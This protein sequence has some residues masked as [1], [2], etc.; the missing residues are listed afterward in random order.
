[1]S[2]WNK[3]SDLDKRGIESLYIDSEGTKE[4]RQEIIA[5]KYG[6]T[7]R[8][9]RNW[10]SNLGITSGV[11]NKAFSTHPQYLKALERRLPNSKYYFVCWEQNKTPLH[12]NLWKNILAYSDTIGAEIIVIQGRY[13]NPTSVWKNAIKNEGWS[14]VTE[15]F[16][17]ASRL[18]LHPYLEAVCDIKIKPTAVNPLTS[19]E[20]I[21]GLNTGIIGH[22]K[23]HLDTIAMPKSY[24][25]KAMLTTGAITVPNYTDSKAGYK[26]LSKHKLG[27]AIVEIKDEEVFYTRQVE[28]DEEGNFYDLFFEVRDGKVSN[29]GE[30]EGIIF[31]DTHVGVQDPEVQQV[32][33]ELV[34]ILNPKR[35]VYHDI[36]DGESVNSHLYKDPVGQYKRYKEG[37][38]LIQSEF[39]LLI[40]FLHDNKRPG[41]YIVRSNH[42]DRFDRYINSMDWRKD[43]HNAESY[44]DMAKALLS[45]EADKGIIPWVIEKEFGDGY[46]KCLDVDDSLRIGK[47]EAGMHGHLGAN[48]SRGGI[49]QFSKID[50]PS[51]TAHG[52]STKR[53]DDTFMTGTNTYRRL[54]YNKGL[55]NWSQSNTIV[56]PNGIAQQIL[57]IEGEYTTLKTKIH[58]N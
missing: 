25:Q 36:I 44:M 22:P 17:Y 5:E 51:I 58:K 41:S 24:R 56:H 6:V 43:I 34:D 50:I 39:D 42:D 48:G 7:A 4:E 12:D 18:I 2:N 21:T 46:F 20:T 38:H 14:R 27:F 10:L 35:L 37:R 49:R 30:I 3:L 19:L 47:Y 15:E 33:R 40:K 45:G 55:T 31:G 16:Q 54:N 23:M 1:M 9:V 52:H 13:Q 57:I 53:I 29:N 32:N 26:A 11:M 28:A 8:T